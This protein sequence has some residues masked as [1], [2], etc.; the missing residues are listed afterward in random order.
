MPNVMTVPLAAKIEFGSFGS[1]GVA[2][3]KLRL[4]FVPLIVEL[5]HAEALV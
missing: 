3:S 4:P 1:L 5:A 2:P